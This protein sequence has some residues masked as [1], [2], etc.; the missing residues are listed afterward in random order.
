MPGRQ[1]ERTEILNSGNHFS[2]RTNLLLMERRVKG[3]R[4]FVPTGKAFDDV[5][6][7]DHASSQHRSW[8]VSVSQYD[9]L[10]M[11]NKDWRTRFRS[12]HG[13]MVQVWG[14]SCKTL[15]ECISHSCLRDRVYTHAVSYM[16]I[17][18]H[19]CNRIPF[20]FTLSL[21]LSTIWIALIRKT[22]LSSPR[23]RIGVQSMGLS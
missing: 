6:T 1:A 3:P 2:F 21:W 13:D 16:A 15:N 19:L 18:T 14:N 4:G 11:R 12:V 5:L 23:N 22:N 10:E 20:S 9:T 17:S 8:C 7:D